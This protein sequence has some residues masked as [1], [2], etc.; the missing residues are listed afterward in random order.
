[1]VDPVYISDGKAWLGPDEPT[2]VAGAPPVT[3][4]PSHR[5]CRG[6]GEPLPD[7]RK[8]F[9]N[10]VCQGAWLSKRSPTVLKAAA[11]KE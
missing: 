11:E 8:G 10:K 1:M 6:C 3:D 4:A 9:H 2:A 5:P 7:N